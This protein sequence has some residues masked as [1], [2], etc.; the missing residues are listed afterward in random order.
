VVRRPK[1]LPHARATARPWCGGQSGCHTHGAAKVAAENLVGCTS[2]AAHTLSWQL[3]D[4]HT[5]R[6]CSGVAIACATACPILSSKRSF[7]RQCPQRLWSVPKSTRQPS[8]KLGA[9]S[10]RPPR[11]R[12]PHAANCVIT[13]TLHQ[14]RRQLCTSV[15]HEKH[16][17][18]VVRCTTQRSH[19]RT[20]HA[21]GASSEA[22][23]CG[24]QH[25][26]AV[27]HVGHCALVPM[28]AHRDTAGVDDEAKG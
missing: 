2:L 19:S 28:R 16:L 25:R 23:R 11:G 1:W 20:P 3:Y 14:L 17:A 10:G 15:V 22:G 24:L 8:P 4:M 7:T 6:S 18:L 13:H 5:R 27:L 9:C 12:V 21:A 26:R